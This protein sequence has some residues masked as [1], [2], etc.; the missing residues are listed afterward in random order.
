MKKHFIITVFLLLIISAFSFAQVDSSGLMKSQRQV[1]KQQKRIDKKERKVERMNRK[2][3]K[4]ANRLSRQNR[5]LDR[6]NRRNNKNIKEVEK[7]QK[8]LEESK[9]DSTRG[10]SSKLIKIGSPKIIYAS[11][12]IPTQEEQFSIIERKYFVKNPSLEN[13]S[14]SRI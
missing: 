13:V 9:T 12:N 8:K 1:E 11:C 10:A 4:Q 3:E 2:Q 7:Q 5:K 6:E 14:T